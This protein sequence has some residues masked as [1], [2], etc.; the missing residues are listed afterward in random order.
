MVGTGGTAIID[1]GCVVPTYS[2]AVLSLPGLVS[3]WRLDETSGTVAK[4]QHGTNNGTY[5]GATL[6]APSLLGGDIDP[7]I[8]LNGTSGQVAIADASSLD[9]TGSFTL[10]A[11]VKPSSVT[12]KHQIISKTSV[13]WIQI[14]D[15]GMEFAFVDPTMAK[16]AL[17]LSTGFAAGV[18]VHV[19]ATYD[20]QALRVYLNGALAGSQAVTAVPGGIVKMG[21]Q[22]YIGTWDGK[23]YFLGGEVDEVFVTSSSLTAARVSKLYAASLGCMH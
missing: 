3:Y 5:L 13:Y 17:T 14:V 19:V 15:G 18:V 11:L 1:G 21:S 23:S 7:A 2:Q 8:L 12:G 20:G 6:G 16:Q 4:D 9:L 22:L 10:S